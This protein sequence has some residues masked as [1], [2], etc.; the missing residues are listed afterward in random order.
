MKS[1]LHP[2]GW[3]ARVFLYLLLCGLYVLTHRAQAL[4][5]DCRHGADAGVPPAPAAAAPDITRRPG[6]A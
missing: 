3:L 4:P 6:A 5:P 2:E 1:Y